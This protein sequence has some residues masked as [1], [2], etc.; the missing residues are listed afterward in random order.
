MQILIA[1]SSSLL[2]LWNFKNKCCDKKYSYDPGINHV[3]MYV[4][5][6]AYLHVLWDVSVCGTTK[7]HLPPLS[8]FLYVL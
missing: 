7:Q 8:H 6:S 3:R 5:G 1:Y 4:C 2:V